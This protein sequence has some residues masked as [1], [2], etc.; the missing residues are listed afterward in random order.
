MQG[1]GHPLQDAEQRHRL[2]GSPATW[3]GRVGWK[4]RHM[5]ALGTSTT[6]DGCWG[7]RPRRSKFQAHTKDLSVLQSP[8]SS[9]QRHTRTSSARGLDSI[10][11]C[12][13]PAH[14]APTARPTSPPDTDESLSPSHTDTVLGTQVAEAPIWHPKVM[15]LPREGS[16]GTRDRAIRG[17]GGSWACLTQPGRDEAGAGLTAHC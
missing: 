15:T 16:P 13:T 4:A 5:A 8:S 14:L 1:L 2:G 7:L 11:T 3:D 6:A 10:P 9:L 12:A 17:G